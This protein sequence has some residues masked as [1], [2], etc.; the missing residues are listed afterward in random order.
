M[1]RGM[2]HAPAA[3]QPRIVWRVATTGVV[4]DLDLAVSWMISV[5]GMASWQQE[6]E[7]G[8]PSPDF[9]LEVASMVLPGTKKPWQIL[10]QATCFPCKWKPMTIMKSIEKPSKTTLF[11]K[12][13]WP[14]STTD[15]RTA[16]RFPRLCWSLSLG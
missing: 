12:P 1:P 10:G 13:A 9:N 5:A 3:F 8:W 14:V 4:A 11:R 2:P 16:A 7:S 6:D 15:P